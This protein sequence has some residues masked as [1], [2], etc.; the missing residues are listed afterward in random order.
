MSDPVEVVEYDSRW[1]EQFARLAAR[2]RVAVPLGAIKAV[3]HIGSTAVPGLAAKS[4]IDLDVVLSSADA[5]PCVV[6]GLAAL[7]YVHEGDKG[8]PGRDAFRWPPGESRHHLYVCRPHAAELRRHLLFR[9]HLRAHPEICAEYAALKRALAAQFR[10][11]RLGYSQA[12]THF[13]SDVLKRAEGRDGE[14]EIAEHIFISG[15]NR[16]S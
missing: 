6:A 12:K 3:E 10:H 7:G 11:D 2:V 14:V 13:V 15:D 8:I 9:D 5:L 4:V 1:P 16:V